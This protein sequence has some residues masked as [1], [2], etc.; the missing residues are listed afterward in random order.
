MN[1]MAK[2]NE[3]KQSI[4]NKSDPSEYQQRLNKLKAPNI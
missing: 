2:V 1:L 3:Y 4:M